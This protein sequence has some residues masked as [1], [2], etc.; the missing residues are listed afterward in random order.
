M[1]KYKSLIKTLPSKAEVSNL[2]RMIDS[3]IEGF[4]KDNDYF[5]SNFEEHNGILRR[6]DEIIN[7][8]ASKLSLYEIE[9]RVKRDLEPKLADMLNTIIH[10]KNEVIE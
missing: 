4:K 5:K 1:A 2:L 7:L 9:S 8:K 6:Y 3:S 10:N